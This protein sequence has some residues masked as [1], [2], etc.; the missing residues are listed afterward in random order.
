MDLAARVKV[1]QEAV[2]AS[3]QLADEFDAWLNQIDP[4]VVKRL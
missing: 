2:G 1:W 3:E 4:L